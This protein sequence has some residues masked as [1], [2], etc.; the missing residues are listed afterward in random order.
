MRLARPPFLIFQWTFGY[1][2]SISTGLMID[3]P[4]LLLQV[5]DLHFQMPPATRFTF[6]WQTL[7][8]QKLIGIIENMETCYIKPW[9]NTWNPHKP[10]KLS[11]LETTACKCRICFQT[12]LRQDHD[13]LS[14][15]PSLPQKLHM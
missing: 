13:L 15:M 3:D 14:T 5:L 1:Q 12:A 11:C 6:S 8:V 10:E 2:T 9:S 7:G 4:F